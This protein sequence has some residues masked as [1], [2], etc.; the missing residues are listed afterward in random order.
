MTD[1]PRPIT[2]PPNA[3]AKGAEVY[4]D[5]AITDLDEANEVD[6]VNS[7]CRPSSLKRITRV[8]ER[9]FVRSVTDH[10]NRDGNGRDRGKRTAPTYSGKASTYGTYQQRYRRWY[11]PSILYLYV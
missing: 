4:D 11:R 2:G 7:E 3:E 10:I 8:V 9:R 6:E 5:L 1:P